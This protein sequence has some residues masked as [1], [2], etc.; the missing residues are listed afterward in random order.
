MPIS[1]SALR[2]LLEEF[3]GVGGDAIEVLTS[4]HTPDQAA[5]FAR[6]ARH[7]GFRASAGSDFHGPGESWLELGA[8]PSLPGDLVPVWASW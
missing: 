2:E 3:R 7:Y 5:L 6:H 4:S 8:L 1:K